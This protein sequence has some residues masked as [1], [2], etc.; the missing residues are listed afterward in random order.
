M[1]ILKLCSIFILIILLIRFKA[2]LWA[3]VL[4]AS[5]WTGLLYQITPIGYIKQLG[6]TISSRNCIELLIITYGL[7]ILQKLMEDRKMLITAEDSITTLTSSAK[8]G[9]VISPIIIGFLPSPAA[10]LMAGTMLKERYEEK[11]PKDTLA[12]IT[13]YFRHIPEALL[14]VYTNVILICSITNV[15][16]WLFLLL[17]L[18]YTTFN[19]IVPYYIYLKPVDLITTKKTKGSHF[20]ILKSILKNIWPVLLITILILGFHINAVIAVSMTVIL[21]IIFNPAPIKYYL[22][23]FK[24]S[25]DVNMFLIVIAILVFTD[26]LTITQVPTALLAIFASSTVPEFIVYGIIVFIGSII[27][28]FT[29]MIPAIFPLAATTSSAPVA[30]IVFL[31]SVGHLA[32]QLCPT[33]ICISMCANQFKVSVNDIFRRTLPVVFIMLT[34]IILIYMIMN[35]VIQF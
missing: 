18:P 12:F 1:T 13:T 26:V 7:I 30:M 11:L 8:A 4:S 29:A 32:S 33:H 27:S 14:P 20:E 25:I 28:S 34:L 3:A 22:N 35:S 19:I 31:A 5:L 15:P 17:M 2:P 16:E 10:V 24:L 21:F 23:F 9:S 6:I